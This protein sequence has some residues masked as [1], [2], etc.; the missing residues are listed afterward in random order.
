[1]GA[2]PLGLS[3]GL[4]QSDDDDD[5]DELAEAVLLLDD[6]SL[7]PDELDDELDAAGVEDDEPERLSVR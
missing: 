5:E 1:M 4:G 3:T 6:E 7:D 2:R